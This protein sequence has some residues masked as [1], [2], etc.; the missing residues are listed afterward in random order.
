MNIRSI[1][2]TLII[3]ACCAL[4]SCNKKN[5]VPK[6]GLIP[7]PQSMLVTEGFFQVDGETRLY[8]DDET[9]FKNEQKQ[10]VDEIRA[11]SGIQ[12][13]AGNSEKEPSK[14]AIVIKRDN[15]LEDEAY[16]LVVTDDLITVKAGSGAG[17]YYALQSLK[18]LLQVNTGKVPAVTISDKPEFKWRGYMLDVSRHFFGIDK[19]YEVVDFMADIKLNRFHIHLVDDQGWRLQMDNY[20]NLTSI[21]A[22]RVDH[23]ITDEKLSNWWGRPAQKD[24][25]KA[26]YGG[27]YTKKQMRELIAY[28]KSK[29]VEIVPEIDVPGHSQE[30]LASYPELACD[31]SR[32]YRVATGGVF[33][34]NALCASNPKTYEFLETV[35]E[36]VAELFPF[37]YIHIGGDECNKSG[38]KNHA[39]CQSLIKKEGLKNEHEL[40]SYFIRRVEKIVNAKGK[41]LIGWDEILEGGLAPNATV[42]SWRGEKGGIAAA[43]E[44]HD[45]IMSPN[46]ANYLDLKQGQSDYEPN[47]GYSEAL[48][49]ACYNYKV[50]PD[51]LTPEQGKHILGTQ[52][53]LWTESISDWGKLTYMTF[54]RLFAVAENGWTPEKYQNFDDFIDRLKVQLERFDAKNIRYAKSVFNPW[55]YQKANGKNIEVSMN[56]ELT[57]PEIRYTLDGTNPTAKSSVYEVPFEIT[58]T[59]TLKAGIFK[60]GELQGDIIEQEFIIHKAV[61]AKV[62]Y[63]GTQPDEKNAGGVSALTDLNYGQF[64][65]KNDKNWQ[66]FNEDVDVEI[67]LDAP[68][69]ISSVTLNTMRFTHKGFYPATEIIVLGS[70][71]GKKFEEIGKTG[72]MKESLIKGRNKMTNKVSCPANGV[73]AIRVIAKLPKALPNDP[74]SR[75]KNIH[76]QI[77]EIIVE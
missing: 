26:T 62:I 43:K 38:W 60:D 46:Y 12:V 55:I 32:T 13:N 66:I 70:T 37:E 20:P 65:G 52:G 18:Q 25:E 9:F 44:G 1:T 74:T 4:F 28:A 59:T 68:T 22:W 56:A 24:G 10:F 2:G 50:I 42:M 11:I 41:H 7:Q 71:D 15:S 30:I 63:H 53:N 57:N 35:I 77:D 5:E 49:S 29:H 14:N 16:G 19:L 64:L 23:N 51:D 3:V 69:N 6:I 48:L 45:V 36:E 72:F 73:T 17:A 47:L 39:A 33:K 8:V 58:K 34:D 75:V 67:Q 27:Y 40:Q 31:H 76:M 21:G 54:P 61:G